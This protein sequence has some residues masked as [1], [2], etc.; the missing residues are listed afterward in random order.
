MLIHS[1]QLIDN[2]HP[3]GFSTG[4]DLSGDIVA[5]GDKAKASGLKI[6]DKVSAMVS[7]TKDNGAFQGG[8]S[9]HYPET[10]LMLSCCSLRVCRD[11]SRDC[12]S[13]RETES[14]H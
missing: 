11:P 12:K 8:I 9:A 5:L 7:N 1:T 6:G 3:P 10:L 2:Y 14:S 4:C 13:A